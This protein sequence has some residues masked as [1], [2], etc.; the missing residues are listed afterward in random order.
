MEGIANLKYQYWSKVAKE[1]EKK[2]LKQ[3][4]NVQ[5]ND[6]YWKTGTRMLNVGNDYQMLK[7]NVE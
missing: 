3:M 6:E 5:K 7:S 2:K 1:H 4:L